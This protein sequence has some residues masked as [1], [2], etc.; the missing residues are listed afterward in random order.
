MQRWEAS[1]LGK[2]RIEQRKAS[3]KKGF[4]K[5]RLGKKG[6]DD[7]MRGPREGKPDSSHAG[8]FHR[9]GFDLGFAAVSP[10][11]SNLRP[12]PC[13]QISESASG[14]RDD[15]STAAFVCRHFGT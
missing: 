10:R 12:D 9:P 11:D 13:D 1:L 5:E 7:Q 3:E 15:L 14:E 4:G 8:A 6:S 2:E